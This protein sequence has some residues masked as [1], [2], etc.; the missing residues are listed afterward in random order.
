[1]SATDR[2]TFQLFMHKHKRNIVTEEFVVKNCNHY[3]HLD[4]VTQEIL[5]MNVNYM[6]FWIGE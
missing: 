5:A 4:K 3:Y 2:Q 1:M 6:E